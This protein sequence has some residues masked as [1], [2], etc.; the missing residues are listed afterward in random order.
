[1]SDK[2]TLVEILTS[3][4]VIVF[5]GVQ[6]G[7]K[8][9]A[10]RGFPIPQGLD[11]EPRTPYAEKYTN[12]FFLTL[13]PLSNNFY[14]YQLDEYSIEGN[15]WYRQLGL[16]YLAS[17]NSLTINESDGMNGRLTLVREKIILD[18][19]RSND[20]PVIMHS[21]NVKLSSIKRRNKHIP[22]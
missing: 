5:H 11:Q 15:Q 7:Y 8:L 16:A 1:M 13:K 18:R 21:D 14:S 10:V 6:H 22:K 12:P 19:D 17:D 4:K 9:N 20:N 3:S 2:Y